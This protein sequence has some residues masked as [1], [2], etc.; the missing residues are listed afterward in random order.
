MKANVLLS[1]TLVLAVLSACAPKTPPPVPAPPPGPVQ[2]TVPPPQP[3]PQRAGDWRD[4]PLTP[5]AWRWSGGGGG[6][7]TA[8]FA[9]AG[10]APL[11][12][13][14]CLTRGTVQITHAGITSAATPMSVTTSGGIFPL[15]SDP[16]NPATTGSSVT[17]PA[18]APVLDA[19]AFSRGRFVIE[20]AGQAPSYLPAWP[21][22]SRV[23]EDC[24]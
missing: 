21:E 2:S 15:M 20:V 17:L 9:Q 10:R 11:L 14:T 23:V 1:G 24:R 3:L 5:G 16:L 22:V 19:M 12:T 18:R 4:A 6:R 8:S 7:S 13:I